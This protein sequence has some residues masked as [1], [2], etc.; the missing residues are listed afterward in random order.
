MSVPYT[1]LAPNKCLRLL[2]NTER[3]KEEEKTG[4]GK[5]NPVLPSFS[6]LVPIWIQRNPN[7]YFLYLWSFLSFS[8]KFLLF[9]SLIWR[10]E[11]GYGFTT[12]VSWGRGN[13]RLREARSDRAS[14]FLPPQM[15]TVKPLPSHSST[16]PFIHLFSLFFA[17]KAMISVACQLYVQQWVR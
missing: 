9:I 11:M 17:I 4:V 10:Y 15:L 13:K 8:W 12:C 3:R 16:H 1:Y 6:T 2:H 5:S 14:R 7:V